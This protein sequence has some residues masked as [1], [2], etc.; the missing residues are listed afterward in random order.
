MWRLIMKWK[1]YS[2]PDDD[3]KA[4]KH[5]LENLSMGV[6]HGNALSTRLISRF[7]DMRGQVVAIAF[8]TL[9]I[10]NV[11]EFR[12]AGSY[13]DGK[14]LNDALEHRNVPLTQFPI[15]GMGQFIEKYL[16]NSEQSVVVCENWSASR[17][18]IAEWPYVNQSRMVYFGEQVYHILVHGDSDPDPIDSTIRESGG[19]WGIG[20][21]SRCR[22]VPQ[23]EIELEAFFDEIVANT[24]HIF[25][26]A[27]DGEGYLVWS[28]M[29]DGVPRS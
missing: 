17:S 2:L 1:Y 8:E 26:P 9:D 6:H 11:D 19:H 18:E 14:W 12:W 23:T 27:F 7:S 20:V 24:T 25:V 16:Q 22:D 21:C 29:L 3:P 13:A 28:P 4:K 15:A 10:D 5:V